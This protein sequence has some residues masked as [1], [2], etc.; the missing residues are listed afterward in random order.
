M[1]DLTEQEDLLREHAE[2]VVAAE[3]RLRLI[4][5]GRDEAIRAAIADGMS[6][7][8]IAQVVGISQQA[9]A[10]IRDAA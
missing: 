7:Y 5:D 4:R 9:V 1:G 2:D 10:R 6:M 8:R 3:E